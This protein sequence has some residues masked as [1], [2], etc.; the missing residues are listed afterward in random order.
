[1]KATRTPR[2]KT[3]QANIGR[4]RVSLVMALDVT[5]LRQVSDTVR[6]L[7]ARSTDV[8]PR[9][10]QKLLTSVPA[11]FDPD[12]MER[13]SRRYSLARVV[14]DRRDALE[15]HCGGD[16]SYVQRSLVKRLVWLELLTETYEQRVANGEEVDVGALTQLNNTLKGL[17]KDIGIRPTARP[18]RRLRDVMQGAA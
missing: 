8:A 18:I 15:A 11:K 5:A 13:L 10:K 1:M 12:F 17:Y 2:L 6:S 14:H 16:L 4:R 7:F 3:I 9:P